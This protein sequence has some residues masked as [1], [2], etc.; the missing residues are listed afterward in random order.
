MHILK[1]FAYTRMY[2]MYMATLFTGFTTSYIINLTF[3]RLFPYLSFFFNG[4]FKT[5]S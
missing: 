5:V 1:R 4:I 2:N 3:Q